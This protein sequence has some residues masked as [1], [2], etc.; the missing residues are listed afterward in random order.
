MDQSAVRKGLTVRDQAGNKLGEVVACGQSSFVIGTGVA[1]SP[2]LA[3][4]HSDIVETR[5]D[6][7]V[8]GRSADEIRRREES[9]GTAMPSWR[10]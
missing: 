6:E 9:E 2:E 10:P 3:V 4:R 8:L 1:A 5:D 7:I